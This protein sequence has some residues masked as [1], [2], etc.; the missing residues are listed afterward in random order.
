M[1]LIG[2]LGIVVSELLVIAILFFYPLTNQ[3][4]FGYC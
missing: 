4:P 3:L 2:Q 1:T